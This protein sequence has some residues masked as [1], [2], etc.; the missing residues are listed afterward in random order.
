MFDAEIAA[1]LL[2]RW[3]HRPAAC[4]HPTYLE[5]LREG[6]LNFTHQLGYVRIKGIADASPCN[7]ENIE[8][9]V[10]DDG[11]RALRISAP[12]LAPGWTRWAALEPPQVF[13]PICS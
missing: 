9:L 8:S 2:N 13:P 6:N 3:N 12:S 4:D 1:T 10:F 5:L 11:S 7:I